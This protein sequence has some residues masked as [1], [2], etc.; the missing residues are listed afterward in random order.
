MGMTTTILSTGRDYDHS[1][2]EHDAEYVDGRVVE[3]PMP[4][5]PHSLMQA[6]LTYV[7]F[8]NAR[9]LGFE[10]MTELRIRTT[11]TRTRI[12]D[13]CLVRRVVKTPR[14]PYL[15]IEILSPED[16]AIDAQTKI[17]EYLSHGVEY[18]WL[19][20]PLKLTGS[21]HTPDGITRVQDGMF[22]SGEIRIDIRAVPS[23]DEP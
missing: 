6:F 9:K 14:V 15:C 13:V 1:V 2:F 21:I 23:L 16:S 19:I 3:R 4:T 11:P 18:V 5:E 10:I 7:L 12:P 20:D 17:D 8:A 22:V